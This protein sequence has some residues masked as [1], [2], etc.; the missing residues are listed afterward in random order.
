V[1]T[2]APTPPP[3]EEIPLPIS[4]AA[5]EVYALPVPFYY[6]FENGGSDRIDPTGDILM[7]D[8]IGITGTR[9]P[10]N[11][12]DGNIL[13]KSTR[14]FTPTWAGKDG[15]SGVV[16]KGFFAAAN[17]EFHNFAL[18]RYTAHLELSYGTKGLKTNST[19]HI[20]VWP[21]QLIVFVLVLLAILFVV[22]RYGI[23]HGEKWVVIKAEKML[24]KDEEAKIEERVEEKLKEM[25]EKN[26]AKVP[27]DK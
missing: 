23:L 8:T 21:W 7:K 3:V 27:A 14:R 20:F 26:S 12:V 9:F 5:S 2:V 18:G 19:V 6:K 25:S 22:L 11:P 17:Y 24:E 15:P 1:L 10:G 16:P 4:P 13:P